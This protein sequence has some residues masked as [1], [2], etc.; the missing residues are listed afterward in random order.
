MTNCCKIFLLTCFALFL[1]QIVFADSISQT[2]VYELAPN[3]TVKP[4][5]IVIPRPQGINLKIVGREFGYS[6]TSSNADFSVE[7]E[8]I[9]ETSYTARGKLTRFNDSNE[10]LTAKFNI[11][12]HMGSEFI[13][14]VPTG[15]NLTTISST[16]IL[17]WLD[18]GKMDKSTPLSAKYLTCSI[19]DAQSK[20][21]LWKRIVP[22]YLVGSRFFV[23]FRFEKTKQYFLTVQAS[24][25]SGRQSPTSVMQINT[26]SQTKQL[27]RGGQN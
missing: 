23:N 11:T 4:W 10:S 13:S 14:D 16:G 26:T 8:K 6:V 22:V 27:E 7:D 19:R 1:S 15:P 9:T 20:E 3:E 12:I 24:N 25:I 2:F 21:I 5:S 18:I 17:E